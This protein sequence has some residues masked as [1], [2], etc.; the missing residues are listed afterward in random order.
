M[1]ATHLIIHCA[2]TY[3]SMN[4]GATEIRKW[5]TDKGWRDIGYHYVI[6]RDGTIEKGREDDVI[7]AHARGMNE[8]SLG[9]CLVGGKNKK[10]GKPQV[11]YTYKQWQALKD[12]CI[13][14]K[15][16]DNYTI[17]G[18]NNVPNSGKTCPNFNVKEWAKG[19]EGIS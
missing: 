16:V 13:K 1:K 8:I 18:H 5:H 2:D 15:K 7:G 3:P 6:R 17:I 11:D 9:I 19:L 4:I 12:L 14:L 10:T